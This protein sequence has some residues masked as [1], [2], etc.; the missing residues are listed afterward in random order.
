MQTTIV[1]PTQ[2]LDIALRLDTA[3]E[4]K[5]AAASDLYSER[6]KAKFSRTVRRLEE[7]VRMIGKS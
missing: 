1:T 7:E 2:F 6:A 5:S 4:L 3:R